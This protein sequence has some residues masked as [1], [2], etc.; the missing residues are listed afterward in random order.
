MPK[1]K[2]LLVDWQLAIEPLRLKAI[3]LEKKFDFEMSQE[4]K[5][6]N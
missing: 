1:I 5:A 6:K 3:A 2:A 4:L